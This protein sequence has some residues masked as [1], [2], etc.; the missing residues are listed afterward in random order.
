MF[1][2]KSLILVFC[3]ARTGSTYLCDRLTD[4]E[5]LNMMEFFDIPLEHVGNCYGKNQHKPLKDIFIEICNYFPHKRFI[6]KIFYEHLEFISKNR[7]FELL[8]LDI[9]KKIIIL[10]RNMKETF[11]SLKKALDNNEWGNET[12]NTF[13]CKNKYT[14]KLIDN[15]DSYCTLITEWYRFLINTFEKINLEYTIIHFSDLI[16]KDF[17]IPN[18]VK[19]QF[20]IIKE[21]DVGIFSLFLQVINTLHVIEYYKLE[22]IPI[23]NFT[24]GCIYY[25]K[26]NVWE[27]YFKPLNSNYVSSLIP[28]LKNT[29]TT[30]MYYPEILGKKLD[31]NEK[32]PFIFSND[33]NTQYKKMPQ[34]KREIGKNIIDKYIIINSIISLKADKIYDTI[35]YEYIIGCHIR[36]TDAGGKG[37]ELPIN[38]NIFYNVIK[39]LLYKTPNSIIY[40]A[41]DEDSI[42]TDFELKFT[43]NLVYN[44][45]LR[46]INNE[47]IETS[48][49]TG[50]G[51]PHFITKNPQQNAE[52]V[53]IDYLILSKCD[54]FISNLS[55]VS[56]A[57]LL[58]SNMPHIYIQ[59]GFEPVY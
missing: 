36:G 16:K 55:S 58:N 51:M 46:H 42:I 21:R 32:I 9:E 17:I 30:K 47:K 41:T 1:N 28:I 6:I 27:E 4:D 11:K 40:L 26:K 54:I 57:V 3:S 25:N 59:N 14:Y 20:I 35:K 45:C 34:S 31:N 7:I 23:V 10:Q 37:R 5:T 53:I 43:K 29:I 8:N 24:E 13:I 49:P 2:S 56:T 18:Y 48:G 44:T 12:N 22:I 52:E 38:L 50:C 39:E 33:Q 19:N 15:Y